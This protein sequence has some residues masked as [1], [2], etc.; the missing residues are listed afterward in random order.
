ML[1]TSANRASSITARTYDRL[2]VAWVSCGH[3][4]FAAPDEWQTHAW[5][6]VVLYCSAGSARVTHAEAEVA[7]SGGSF[8]VLGNT[9]TL[10][11]RAE[12][13]SNVLVL[14]I[15]GET[16]SPYTQPLVAAQ[17]SSIS[18]ENA[19]ANLVAHLL[20]GLTS[21]PRDYAPKNPG[22]LAQHIVGLIALMCVD[23]GASFGSG[24]A[25]MLYNAKQYI[26]AH[27]SESDLTP[28][29]VAAAQNISTRTLH[30]LFEGDGLTISGWTRRRRLEQCRIDLN[31]KAFEDLPVSAIG[32]RW[33]LPDPAQ[34]SRL[35]RS[36]FGLSPTA[37]RAAAQA[38]SNHQSASRAAE[39]CSTGQT[40]R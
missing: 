23:D 34:F 36:T 11:V 6:F 39:L 40:S 30:R 17:A 25:A 32:T 33:G 5:P 16:V 37:Y 28:D 27:L 20:E 35:F 15:P 29:R 19:T 8:L 10:A 18:A 22:R 3:W 14:G 38:R 1:A 7:M 21:Q 26:E 9:G 12:A 2:R 31:D 24:R 4:I 13:G